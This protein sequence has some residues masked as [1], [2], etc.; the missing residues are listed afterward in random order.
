VLALILVTAVSATSPIVHRVSVGGPDLCT[1]FDNR[2]GCDANFSFTAKEYADGSA[3]GEYTDR[4]SQAN[5]GGGFHAVIDCVSVVGNTAWVSG[6]ITNGFVTDPETGEVVDVTGFPVAA[7]V[8][9]NGTTA[10]DPPDK[11]SL[12]RIGDPRPC[13]L[14]I[15]Y[16]I[17]DVPQGQVNVR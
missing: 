6:V 8:Q 12:S 3:S 9:D 1:V 5:G 14:H 15:P 17:F 7:R 13:T 4:F 16:R 2:P 11:I 10:N